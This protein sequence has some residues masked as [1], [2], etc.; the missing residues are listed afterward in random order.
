MSRPWPLRP[1][2]PVLRVDEVFADPQVRH[3][4]IAEPVAH[5]RRGEIR[6]IAQAAVLSRTPARIAA[7]L[8]EQ[9]ADTD[10]VLTEAGLDAAAI[11]ALRAAG[12]F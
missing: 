1:C 5:P 6:L 7:T 10:E 12:A 4:G 8:S 9:G 2:G 11:A 3:L